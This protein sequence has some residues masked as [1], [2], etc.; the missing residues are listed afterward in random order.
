MLAPCYDYAITILSYNPKTIKMM[1]TTLLAKW[2]TL[3]EI[4]YTINKLVEQWYLDDYAFC[5]AYFESEVINKWK[6]VNAIK[7]KM[8]EKGMPSDILKTVLEELETEIEDNRYESLAK[9][10]QKLHKQ[11]HDLVKIYEKLV[12][13]WHRYDDIKWALEYIKDKKE[14]NGK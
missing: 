9:E 2:Y 10:I 12:R 4:D 8:Y 14:W 6:S 5:K 1:H 3:K 7:K 13:K 11:W